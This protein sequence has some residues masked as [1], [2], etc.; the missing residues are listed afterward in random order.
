MLIEY[1]LH[2]WHRSC[3]GLLKQYHTPGKWWIGGVSPYPLICSE[4][5]LWVMINM[6]V[7]ES[8]WVM[9]ASRDTNYVVD[10]T[11]V[12]WKDDDL[13]NWLIHPNCD[14]AWYTPGKTTNIV[15]YNWRTL[16]HANW[17]FGTSWMATHRHIKNPLSIPC[18]YGFQPTPLPAPSPPGLQAP[19]DESGWHHHEN[20]GV[21]SSRNES[22]CKQSLLRHLPILQGLLLSH[23]FHSDRHHLG[24]LWVEWVRL[25]GDYW[26]CYWRLGGLRSSRWYVQ[27]H[28]D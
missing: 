28:W 19:L 5:G 10:N 7:W 23:H 13:V 21:W 24:R 27:I 20:K 12:V 1:F 8:V 22:N 4:E 14:G 15:I 16:H 2:G 3:S 18:S 26:S 9:E 11:E 6:S 25:A 17:A